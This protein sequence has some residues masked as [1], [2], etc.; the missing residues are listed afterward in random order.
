MSAAGICVVGL[1]ITADVV[2]RLARHPIPG[3]YELTELIM[4]IVVFAALAYTQREKGHIHVTMF[5]SKLPLAARL[6]VFGVMGAI[7]TVMAGMITYGAFSQAGK[8]MSTASSSAVLEM[9][10]YPFYY[11]E[12]IAMALFTLVLLLDTLKAFIGIRNQDIAH[13]VTKYWD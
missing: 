8:S 6:A 9:P 10:L 4:V 12:G 3:G 1:L 11:I 7:S 2:L 5:V 13:D